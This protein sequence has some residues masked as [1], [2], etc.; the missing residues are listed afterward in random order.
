MRYRRVSSRCKGTLAYVHLSCLERWLNQSCR[1]YCE[2]C[3]Y[4]FNAVETPRYRW[5]ESLRIWISHPRNRRN[6]ESDLLILTLLTI[7][8][9][10]LTAI[11]LLGEWLFLYIY[12]RDIAKGNSNV[13]KM[14]KPQTIS[15]PSDKRATFAK[16][17][18]HQTE[19]I[20]VIRRNFAGMRYFIIEGKKIGVSKVWTRGAIWFFLTIVILGYAITVYLLCRVIILPIYLFSRL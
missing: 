11:C 19:N 3:R 1:T 6:I 12:R 9:V 7:V 4:Y 17:L 15:V 5:P 8:T 13:I 18:S 10:G 14:T 20:L 2:L 16:L